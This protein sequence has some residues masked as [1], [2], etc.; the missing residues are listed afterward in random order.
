MV[1]WL[2]TDNEPSP[3]EQAHGTEQASKSRCPQA[4]GTETHKTMLYHSR[5]L[6][7]SST[8]PQRK[9]QSIGILIMIK[10]Y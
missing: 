8:I 9:P 5:L 6:S 4:Q 1:V 10:I 2:N 3:A 7:F